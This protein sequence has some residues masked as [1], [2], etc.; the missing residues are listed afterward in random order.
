LLTKDAK[1]IPALRMRA[2]E[3]SLVLIEDYDAQYEN[4]YALGITSFPEFAKT[5]DM[6]AMDTDREVFLGDLEKFVIQ[7]ITKGD[8]AA[9]L[10][11]ANVAIKSQ[12]VMSDQILARLDSQLEARIGRIYTG[13]FF[14]LGFSLFFVSLAL[15]LMLAFYKV[16]MGGLSEVAGH[17]GQ[18]TKGNLTTAPRPWGS[19]EAAQL[20]VTLGEMQTSLRRIVGIVLESS[21]GVQTASEEIAS[22]SHDL[23][24][25][26]ENS[27]SSLQTTAS[28]MEEISSTV[29]H[30]SDTVAG[31][32]AIVRDNASSAERGGQVIS[33]VV[34]TMEGI[35]TSSHQI[36]E[37]ISVID[38][39]AF[40]TNILAL[41]AAVEAARA[42]EQGRGF[43]VVATEV[44]ALA[45]RSAAAAK[46]IKTLISASISQVEAGNQVVA[47][48]GKTIGEIVANA[49]KID[50][51]MSEIATATREQSQGVTQVTASV[52]ELD[53]GTQQNAALV[54]ET[55]AAASSLA[56]QAQR[57]AD[58][59]SFF[60]LS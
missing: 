46:E 28:A 18:I 52:N 16:M 8:T 23:A 27:A 17:L 19:D 12:L 56:D 14:Q 32:T 6:K 20:M 43:A 49:S 54:E 50:A 36:G 10:N 51:M 57:L 39:I 7:D 15:Y 58:E 24:R 53:E 48:A 25:R 44:R 38:G 29:M 34:Q 26:T 33:Q 35:R 37:I 30:T 55:A 5:L 3:K 2:I 59:V 9:L 13:F 42:G 60:K 1:E 31:A 41:N 11:L 45:G 22:A 40:Q 4:S 47:E 21:G